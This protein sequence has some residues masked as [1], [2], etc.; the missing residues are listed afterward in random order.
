MGFFQRLL[1]RIRKQ[2]WAVDENPETVW[3]VLPFKASRKLVLSKIEDVFPDAER[4]S[5]LQM[6]DRYGLVPHEPERERVQLAIL[7]LCEGDK[8]QLRLAV[9]DAKSDFRDVLAWAEYPGQMRNMGPSSTDDSGHLARIDE[10]D[11]Q[12]YIDW[13]N[14]P[15]H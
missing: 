2:N 15:H 11:R 3:Q 8:E 7:K 12:Q 5:V 10:Q 6:L 9:D 1:A 4:A 14:G 13:M